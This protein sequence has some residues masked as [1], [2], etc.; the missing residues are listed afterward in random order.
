MT[1]WLAIGMLA[2]LLTACACEPPVASTLDVTLRAQGTSM[3]CWA[4]SGQMIMEF[5]GHG[6]DQP[7]QANNRLG[8]T[9]CANS[10]TPAGC[11]QGGWPEFDRYGFSF[12]TT[13]DAPLSWSDLQRQI[14]CSKK[15]FAFS[16][17]WSGGGGHMLV[18]IGYVTISGVN[19]VVVN[20]PWPPPSA[21]VTGGDQTVMTYDAYVSGSG[22]THWDDYYNV[23]Y[24]ES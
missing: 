6:V 18:A 12:D 15:P 4:A 19:Y 21:G 22:Y 1:R 2:T 7:T 20:D 8:R 13:S 23:T 16:W 3:W 14:A 17:H 11:V 24:T 5:L 9:D 10:P